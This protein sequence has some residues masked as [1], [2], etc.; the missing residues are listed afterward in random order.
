M[1]PRPPRLHAGGAR[2]GRRR[3]HGPRSGRAR[4]RR[5]ARRGGGRVLRGGRRDVRTEAFIDGSFAPSAEGATFDDVSPRDGTVIASVAAGAAE[6]VD[7][8]V[9][10]A[11]RAFDAGGWALADPEQRKRVLLALA[12]LIDEHA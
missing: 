10:A 7:R 9:R 4:S 1:D 8:A 12:E 5:R 3:R 2:R 11:R 6:D